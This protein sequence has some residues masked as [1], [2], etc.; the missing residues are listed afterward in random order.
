VYTRRTQ[1]K[2]KKE[3]APPPPLPPLSQEQLDML[4]RQT[5]A[6]QMSGGKHDDGEWL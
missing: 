4:S 5:E 3:E 1:T 6:T 2:N